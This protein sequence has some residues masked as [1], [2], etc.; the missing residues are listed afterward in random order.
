MG[1]PFWDAWFQYCMAHVVRH[2]GLR[3]RRGAR[4]A[5]VAPQVDGIAPDATHFVVSVWAAMR[6]TKLGVLQDRTKFHS[7]VLNRLATIREGFKADY[8]SM[9]EH[10]DNR[11]NIGL[12]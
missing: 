11:P 5:D 3:R 8:R 7:G 1:L 6:L 2:I 12:A 9:L 10:V 4:I